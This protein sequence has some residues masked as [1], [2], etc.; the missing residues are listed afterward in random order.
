MSQVLACLELLGLDCEDLRASLHGGTIALGHPLGAS[1]TRL[2]PTAAYGLQ[3]IEQ[4][5]MMVSPYVGLG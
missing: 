5:Y 4:C 3:C 1:N 2:V